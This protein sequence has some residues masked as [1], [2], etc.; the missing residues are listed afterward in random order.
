MNNPG[1]IGRRL[2]LTSGVTMAASFLAACTQPEIPP[3]PTP[4]ETQKKLNLILQQIPVGEK[5]REDE[6]MRWTQVY[7]R[8]GQSFKDDDWEKEEV[9]RFQALFRTL[10]QS[11]IPAIQDMM[12]SYSSQEA[13]LTTKPTIGRATRGIFGSDFEFKDNANILYPIVYLDRNA[14]LDRKD[15]SPFVTTIMM[16]HQYGR[17]MTILQNPLVTAAKTN[18]EK[19]QV[20]N[21]L[22][23]QKGKEMEE[24][25][26][27]Y[28]SKVFAYFLAFTKPATIE[29]QST[30]L[31]EE[32]LMQVENGKITPETFRPLPQT[33]L[34][35][36]PAIQI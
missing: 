19:L 7:K 3:T 4:T 13:F 35:T 20:I 32:L 33:P 14:V 15:S 10:N 8:W 31:Y 36:Y 29:T 26:V 34:P 23:Q 5:E 21:T 25:R 1:E 28:G 18:S 11:N 12:K 16:A 22:K 24:A 27:F 9:E 17:I 6:R 30:S 2:F